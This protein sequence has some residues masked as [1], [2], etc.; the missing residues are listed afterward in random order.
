MN[1]LNG[2]FQPF[3]GSVLERALACE[4]FE[5]LI[6][7]YLVCSVRAQDVEGRSDELRLYRDSFSAL[8]FTGSEGLLDSVNASGCITCEF[9]VSTELDGLR[10]QS[11]ADSA[12][13]DR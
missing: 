4:H 11:T 2:T 1:G 3:N 5:G 7:T 6:E 13:Q 8:F 10:G 9:N 12:N